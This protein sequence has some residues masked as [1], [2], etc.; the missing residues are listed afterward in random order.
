MAANQVSFTLPEKTLQQIQSAVDSGDFASPEEFLARAVDSYES[1]EEAL[2]R[3]LR[4]EAVA[5]LERMDA[6]PSRRFSIAQVRAGLG[7]DEEDS[8]AA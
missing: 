5:I 4:T 7:L 3:F 1:E 2:Q 6:D 8:E